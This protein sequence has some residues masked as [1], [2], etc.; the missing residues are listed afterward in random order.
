MTMHERPAD[1]APPYPWSHPAVCGSFRS[2]EA[3]DALV[4]TLMDDSWRAAHVLLKH[5]GRQGT[6]C[7]LPGYQ[8]Y[9]TTFVAPDKPWGVLKP[10]GVC[11]KFF[12]SAEV[13]C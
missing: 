12:F 2:A 10:E 3:A 9:L 4:A 5:L 1:G 6:L 11:S 8:F 13:L 7:Q